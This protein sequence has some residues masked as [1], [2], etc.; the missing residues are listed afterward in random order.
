MKISLKDEICEVVKKAVLTIKENN[1]FGAEELLEVA[2]DLFKSKYTMVKILCVDILTILGE[3]NFLLIDLLKSTNW[4]IRLKVSSKLTEFSKEEQ[5]QIINELINDPLEEIRIELAKH[6]GSLEFV[7]L[8]DDPSEHVRG[9]YLKGIMNIIDNEAIL[10]KALDDSSWEVR[11]TLLGLKGEMFKKITIPLIRNKTENVP[12]RDKFEILCLVEEK[13]S[14]E[15]ISKLLMVFLLKHIK[16]KVFE[17][18]QQVQRILLKVVQL[19]SWIAEYYYEIEALTTSTNYLHRISITPVVIEYD[20]R[21]KTEM[22]KKLRDDKVINVRECFNDYC[23]LNGIKL[24]Y[25]MNY[26]NQDLDGSFTNTPVE[27]FKCD[28]NDSA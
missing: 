3:K 8:L 21:F 10:R 26:N 20:L 27:S 5:K 23:N 25:M 18:R 14:D 24:D 7:H 13:A 22:S 1:P 4:R 11:K 12:W 28:K 6:L 15:F 2:I 17:V 19:H 9:N 16:D